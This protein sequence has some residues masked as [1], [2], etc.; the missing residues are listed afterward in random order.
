[1]CRTIRLTLVV[2][3]LAL[4]VRAD[5]RIYAFGAG[6]KETTPFALLARLFEIAQEPGDKGKLIF[7][8]PE[9]EG[10]DGHGR[11][12]WPPDLVGDG[13][14]GHSAEDQDVGPSFEHTFDGSHEVPGEALVPEGFEGRGGMVRA[15]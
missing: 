15:R 12:E 6:R 8:K 5:C 7:S 3:F 11:V 14:S 2:P 9:E 13:E 10:Y 4:P 1:M